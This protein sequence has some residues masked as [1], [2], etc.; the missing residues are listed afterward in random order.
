CIIAVY[1]WTTAHLNACACGPPARPSSPGTG[2]GCGYT[3]PPV[4]MPLTKNHERVTGGT[5]ATESTRPHLKDKPLVSGEELRVVFK[6]TLQNSLRLIRCRREGHQ[7]LSPADEN[8]VIVHGEASS[9]SHGRR[10][11][12][13]DRRQAFFCAVGDHRDSGS[14]TLRTSKP[15]ARSTPAAPWAPPLKSFGPSGRPVACL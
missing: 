13:A 6:K 11:A 1:L 14:R 4:D 2:T 12:S 10:S 15:R 3:K 8:D 9:S 5:S 7:I